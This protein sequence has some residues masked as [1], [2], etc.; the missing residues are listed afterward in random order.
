[1]AGDLEQSLV[2]KV[3]ADGTLEITKLADE[4][5]KAGQAAD[6]ATG[7]KFLSGIGPA[8]HKAEESMGGVSQA[9]NKISGDIEAAFAP[10]KALFGLFAAFEGGRAIV[11]A[12]AGL[13]EAAA[14][15]HDSI[16][17]LASSVER[18]G[19]SFAELG[20][21]IEEAVHAIAGSST[22][23]VE[24]L[25]KAAALFTTLT[26]KATETAAALTPIAD[27][28]A[29]L[30]I[31]LQSS[32]TLI[33]KA[34]EGMTTSLQR[35]GI[36]FSDTE[37]K[38]LAAAD[39]TERLA[40]IF[41]KVES[42]VGGAAAGQLRTFAGQWDQLK[43]QFH[44]VAIV[45]GNELLPL[46]STAVEAT[47][48]W[49]PVLE[50]LAGVLQFIGSAFKV[51][52]GVVS[53]VFNEIVAGAEGIGLAVTF[54][55]EKMFQGLAAAAGGVGLDSLAGK[56]H[57]AFETLKDTRK[58]LQDWTI[59]AHEAATQGAAMFVEGLTGIPAAAEKAGSGIANLNRLFAD[60]QAGLDKL[61]N[62]V[63]ET[64]AK[65]AEIGPQLLQTK[66][67]GQDS[68]LKSQKTSIQLDVTFKEPSLDPIEQAID[69]ANKKIIDFNDSLTS[70]IKE[71]ERQYQIAAAQILALSAQLSEEEKKGAAQDYGVVAQYEA[72]IAA[73]KGLLAQLRV[74]QSVLDGV[75]A[76]AGE[77]EK[78]FLETE[79]DNALAKAAMAS[80]K[81][82][83]D[84]ENSV[85]ALEVS[86]DQT[87]RN[88][89]TG[90]GEQFKSQAEEMVK[91]L[92]VELEKLHI[93]FPD[94][95]VFKE[96]T[97]PLID[98]TK[99][100]VD[101]LGDGAKAAGQE[102]IRAAEDAGRKMLASLQSSVDSIFGNLADLTGAGKTL[103]QGFMALVNDASKGIA[104][105]LYQAILGI[106]K[107]EQGQYV[108]ASG[109]S[110]QSLEGA[111]GA[112][113]SE[114]GTAA[115]AGIGA[116]AGVS[117]GLSI[118]VSQVAA[119]KAASAM[120][121][122]ANA[123]AA[124][125]STY[126]T[127]GGWIAAI[128][129]TV[130]S[131]IIGIIG[132]AVAKGKYPY[133]VPGID[134]QGQATLTEA[135][136]NISKADSQ[137]IL[138]KTQATFDQF[139]DG[140]IRILTTLPIDAFPT[141]FKTIDGRFDPQKSAEYFTHLDQWLRG[142]LP[143][144]IAGKF[145]VSMSS[146]FQQMG[147]SAEKFKYVWD[148]LQTLDPAKALQIAQDWADAVVALDKSLKF[149]EA[150]AFGSGFD[151]KTG[152]FQ[153][154]GVDQ[155]RKE[156]FQS[157]NDSMAQADDHI[158]ALAAGFGAL[159][160]EG[161]IAAAKE[162]T[163]LLDERMA[164]EKAF[165]K[166]VADTIDAISKS[167]NDKIRDLTVQTMTDDKGN[168]D[169]KKQSDYLT[170]YLNQQFEMLGKA[171]TPQQVAQIESE[172]EATIEKLRQISVASGATIQAANDWAIGVLE[173]LRRESV[174]KLDQLAQDVADENKRF[175]DA[176][177]GFI[178]AF[179]KA[180]ADLG[181][182]G[183]PGSGTTSPNTN[184]NPPGSGGR[185]GDGGEA[186]GQGLPP[187]GSFNDNP[188]P[189]HDPFSGLTPP[190]EHT[191]GKP[192]GGGA[193]SGGVPYQLPDGSWIIVPIG[194]PTGGGDFVPGHGDGSVNPQSAQLAFDDVTSAVT[195]GA[196]DQV[197]SIASLSELLRM[198]NNLLSSI[199][200]RLAEG[201][202]ISLDPIDVT[203]TTDRG[204]SQSFRDGVAAKRIIRA[205]G[206]R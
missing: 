148:K 196:A 5:K 2:I 4:L 107:N 51:F 94:A 185:G 191:G 160:F 40:L 91:A 155:A 179:L 86:I 133:A 190:P 53:G 157:F 28:S 12:L 120:A 126:L 193:R 97:Q 85:K 59:A 81:A 43:S 192:T 13:A 61:I 115:S 73:Q 48:A 96:A 14:G 172:I 78:T 149:F 92:N 76:R 25:E 8:S 60:A 127:T 137:D 138:A 202:H 52:A 70:S 30:G 188:I 142:T 47:K 9:I 173:E 32:A 165:Y 147:V 35:A 102:L 77:I 104:P 168:P 99:H 129:A 159:S 176:I 205:G 67:A 145:E 95:E 123:V 89:P 163:G 39:S 37:Q 6:G 203:V 113:Q 144:E 153:S 22:F 132:S 187:G 34:A 62:R 181:G 58:D 156:E 121:I 177:Q 112:S 101:I 180:T 79:R 174:A 49:V 88:L 141:I 130:V 151:S 63:A 33:S 56:L 83:A 100:A 84:A 154:F 16:E 140:Y 199:D 170:N 71:T 150:P 72:Q 110:Y 66:F 26:G 175:I 105:I 74:S 46:M 167:I 111:V 42:V 189:T 162:L 108:T 17:N 20:P 75:K 7:D 119:K 183:G 80:A 68:I 169:Y 41:A 87:F 15:A 125:I 166:E 128:V 3:R 136:K 200:R 10:V 69:A 194:G 36:V 186:G 11:E 50:K 23:N 143:R 116:L 135:N 55:L 184:T 195:T 106:K 54:A 124:G 93:L 131:A 64:Q 24:P 197:R 204:N 18:A 178:D 182:Q 38:A 152:D 198:N 65:L 45:L 117:A 171:T 134:A 27:L 146:A 122:A 161:Q 206:L 118:A 1:M 90:L 201:E 158:K 82:F 29:A 31:D 21:G 44:E 57:G 114:L 19:H 139:Y 98:N 103:G 164:K 109:K